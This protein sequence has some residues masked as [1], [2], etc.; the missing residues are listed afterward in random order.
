VKQSRLTLIFLSAL[1]V[2]TLAIAAEIF[3]VFLQPV[4]FAAILGVG[5][6]PL[7]S[8]I[9]GWMNNKGT[10]A[11]LSTIIVLLIFVLPAGF[12][13]AAVSSEM[14]SAGR[15]LAERSRQAGGIQELASHAVSRPMEWVQRH[16]DLEKTGISDWI[17]SLPGKASGA[18]VSGGSVLV[19]GLAGFAGRT[20]ITFFVLFFLF[21]DGRTLL[22]RISALMPLR[23]H[24][25]NRLF[26]GVRDGIVANLYGILG[27]GIVQG[28]LTGLALRVLGVP[29]PLLL[30]VLAGFAS[31]VPVLGTSLVWLPAA[32][33]LIV[34]VHV[35][36]G[37][38]L[39][40]WGALVVASSD[41]V[42][43]PLIVQGRVEIHP[44]LLLFAMLGGIRVFGF[45]GIFIGPIVLSLAGALFDMIREE[46][47]REQTE[48]PVPTPT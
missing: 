27:V 15:Y 12:M 33:Y 39:L 37:I 2:A 47:Q 20:V 35:W 32:I 8:T 46:V 3:W 41:N 45:L 7:H 22:D 13:A 40:L 29:T 24:Q 43:R 14:R 30:G 34:A 4:A 16:V 26:N 42:V 17:A 36:K 48:S 18:L 28:L 38:A 23:G 10:A 31:L 5:L 9:Q 6:Y 1:F 25:I 21:R 44:L 19:R 11:L